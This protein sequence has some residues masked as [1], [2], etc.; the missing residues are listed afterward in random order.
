MVLGTQLLCQGLQSVKDLFFSRGLGENFA[1][2]GCVTDQEETKE[3]EWI[4]NFS[5]TNRTDRAKNSLKC[6]TRRP[7]GAPV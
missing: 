5:L 1:L 3:G 2:S 7:P 4:N 6:R